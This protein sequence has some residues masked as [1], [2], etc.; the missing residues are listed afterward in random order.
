[1]ADLRR[2]WK[3]RKSGVDLL[4]P[5]K[6]GIWLGDCTRRISYPAKQ[7]REQRMCAYKKKSGYL[8]HRSRY[9]RSA[10][11]Y[12][13]QSNSILESYAASHRRISALRNVWKLFVKRGPNC[14][15]A[16]K[17]V[18]IMSSIFACAVE[19]T[20]L[21]LR[22]RT[23]ELRELE[24]PTIFGE[25][26]THNAERPRRSRLYKVLAVLH[27]VTESAIFR[28]CARPPSLIVA[29]FTITHTSTII[30]T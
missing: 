27:L 13:K 26:P 29:R 28:N 21:V 3:K 6:S 12:I 25:T 8:Y 11:E 7:R 18:L 15:P 1:M 4:E 10:H 2:N 19:N 9:L 16:L 24:A 14:G 30:M 5:S 22:G 17:C 20:D 23:A